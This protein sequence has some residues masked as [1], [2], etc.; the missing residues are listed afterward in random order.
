MQ[1]TPHRRK[2][3]RQPDS[4]RFCSWALLLTLHATASSDAA[5]LI[6]RPQVILV[7]ASFGLATQLYTCHHTA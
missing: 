2:V 4:H 7:P 5:L 1:V 3:A 6:E